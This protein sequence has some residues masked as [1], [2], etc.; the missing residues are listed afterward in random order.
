[1]HNATGNVILPGDDFV[2]V[3]VKNFI[4]SNQIFLVSLLI[5][6]FFFFFFFF[7]ISADNSQGQ[8]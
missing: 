1:M 3:F 7:C 4:L 8:K 6:F 5:V 2:N